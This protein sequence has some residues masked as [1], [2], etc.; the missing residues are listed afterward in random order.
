MSAMISRSCL[1]LAVLDGCLVAEATSPPTSPPPPPPSPPSP[2]SPPPPCFSY[3]QTQG[4]ETCEITISVL[5]AS[6]NG[7]SLT[8]EDGN[9]V[10][11]T[12]GTTISMM[13]GCPSMGSLVS[14][15]CT[16]PFNSWDYLVDAYYNS[17]PEWGFNETIPAPTLTYQNSA[18]EGYRLGTLAYDFSA[19]PSFVDEADIPFIYAATEGGAVLSYTASG[20]TLQ[21]F[22]FPKTV[23]TVAACVPMGP[24]PEC[25]TYSLVDTIIE[26]LGPNTCEGSCPLTY[27]FGS[28]VIAQE[29]LITQ[30]TSGVIVLQRPIDSSTCDVTTMYAYDANGVL[31]GY[32]QMQETLSIYVT[33]STFTVHYWCDDYE[34]S[35]EVSVSDIEPPPNGESSGTTTPTTP[36]TDGSEGAEDKQDASS[37]AAMVTNA[38]LVVIVVFACLIA[39][40]CCVV[41]FFIIKKRQAQE[42]AARMRQLPVGKGTTS[43]GEEKV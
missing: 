17:D 27:G 5:D 20:D 31:V 28:Q 19:L 43:T 41:A 3:S 42:H 2:P 37:P 4:G 29:M 22:L 13:S 33:T 8:D 23:T 38:Q 11:N 32:E 40:V 34:T 30:T 24:D 14:N 15:V 9:E 16:I 18:T 12:T 6:T 10:V 7:I 39:I 25:S 35:G 1:L 26:E 36:Q 21:S